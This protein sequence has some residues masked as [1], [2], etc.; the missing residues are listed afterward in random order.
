MFPQALRDQA[1]NR[2]GSLWPRLYFQLSLSPHVAG[3]A[4]APGADRCQLAAQTLAR[5]APS[6]LPKRL[7]RRKYLQSLLFLSR[8]VSQSVLLQHL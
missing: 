4:T 5:F 2:R 7:R 1:A 8:D 6:R 3:L